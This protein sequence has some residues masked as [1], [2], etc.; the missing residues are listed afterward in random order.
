MFYSKWLKQVPSKSRV[1]VTKY[2]AHSTQTASASMMTVK[3]DQVN[4]CGTGVLADVNGY[5]NVHCMYT[6]PR[7]MD[8]IMQ[9]DVNE[10]L[11]QLLLLQL[12]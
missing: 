12:L 10:D 7:S 5:N 2:S 8:C 1:Y 11:S 4:T 6:N 9:N 3:L